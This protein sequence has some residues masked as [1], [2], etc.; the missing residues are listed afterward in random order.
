MGL[1]DTSGNKKKEIYR[2]VDILVKSRFSSILTGSF[3][4][5]DKDRHEQPPV[6]FRKRLTTVSL[7]IINIE[8]LREVFIFVKSTTLHLWFNRGREKRRP[9]KWV[10]LYG[11][12]SRQ[13]RITRVEGRGLNPHHLLKWV[14]DLTVRDLCPTEVST[15]E[16]QS[17]G[18][19]GYRELEILFENYEDLI[20]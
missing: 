16:S 5:V 18:I 10:G 13:K 1:S 8:R 14:G 15:G 3:C 2:W 7:V 12:H 4:D 6:C 17:P 20:G 9:V 11:E 19:D